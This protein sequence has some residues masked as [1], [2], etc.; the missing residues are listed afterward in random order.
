MI[1]MN[2]QGSRYYITS[3]CDEIAWFD[4]LETAAIVMRYL[5]GAP[6]TSADY[7]TAVDA[8]RAFDA[9]NP[10]QQKGTPNVTE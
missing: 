10:K 9:Q 2:R 5:K 7:I 3:A 4:S 8:M 6:M 1:E